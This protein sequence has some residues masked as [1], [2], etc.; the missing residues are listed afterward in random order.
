SEPVAP[1]ELAKQLDLALQAEPRLRNPVILLINSVAASWSLSESGR[2]QY[3]RHLG[4]ETQAPRPSAQFDSYVIYDLYADVGP[5]A[6]VTDM[7]EVGVWKQYTPAKRSPLSS[8]IN[9]WIY[10][11]LETFDEQGARQFLLER[12]PYA[13]ML[14]EEPKRR[15]LSLDERIVL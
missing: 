13:F 5:M 4:H 11:E 1:S 10:L 2:F 7:A 3:T 6:I 12:Q 9:P 8:L 14:A 15:E